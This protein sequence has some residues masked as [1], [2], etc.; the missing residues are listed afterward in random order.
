MLNLSNY[1]LVRT[2]KIGRSFPI[3]DVEPCLSFHCILHFFIP[4]L[5]E[6]F[7][8]SSDEAYKVS[9]GDKKVFKLSAITSE[10]DV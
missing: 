8:T 9:L 7:V 2:Q 1:L 10:L 3:Q 6:I 4:G 5:R